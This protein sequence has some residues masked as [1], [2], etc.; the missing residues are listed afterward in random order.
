MSGTARDTVRK[1]VIG[2]GKQRTKQ[3]RKENLTYDA[4]QCPQRE[5]ASS[6][7]RST[8][9]LARCTQGRRRT[10]GR[11][12]TLI[13]SSRLTNGS[14]RES[15]SRRLRGTTRERTDT[16]ITPSSVTRSERDDEGGLS[17]RMRRSRNVHVNALTFARVYYIAAISESREYGFV[18]CKSFFR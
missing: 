2:S 6:A 7:S 10:R 13:E 8:A 15:S 5:A 17:H 11:G 12:E 18:V 14:K 1:R 16:D 4:R 3:G 9:R